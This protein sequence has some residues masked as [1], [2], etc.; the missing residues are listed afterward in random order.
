MRDVPPDDQRT[1][2]Q[3]RTQLEALLVQYGYAA[4][5][6]PI[7]E[8]RDLY[9]RKLGEELV[10]K[11]YEFAFGGRNLALRP[12][13]TASVL[14]AYVAHLQDQPLPL[15]LSYS[16]P[17]F[18]YERPQRL[19]Y[20]QF[21]Q[22]GVEM[23]G[24][25]PPRADA[26]IIALASAGLD[27][28]GVKS[29][30]V[31]IGHLGLVRE[32]LTQL[33]LAERTQGLLAWGLEQ[34]R[35]HGPEAVRERLREGQSDLPFDPVLFQGLDDEQATTLLLNLLRAMRVDLAFGT[36][37]PEDIARRLLRKLRRDESQP[38]ID[39]ALDLLGRLSQ[40]NGIA[41]ETLPQVA[42]LLDEAGL[43]TTTLDEIGAV[44]ALL[45]AHG[46][47]RDR[48]I[49]DF[50][51]GRGLHYYTG[52]IFEMYD[53][54]NIQLC[55]GGRYDDLV[56]ALGGRQSI[57]A[58]GFAYGVERVVA[59]IEQPVD[60]NATRREVLVAPVTDHDYAYALEAARRLRAR[61]FVVTLDVRGRSVTS[62]LRDAARRGIAYVAI[63]GSEERERRE[64]VWRNLDTREE[65]RVSIDEL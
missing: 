55:G 22:V 44:L 16:G 17:V 60:N 23:V 50:G 7:V 34:I 8:H 15:R 30:R 4:L 45:D 1:L 3:V 56:L 24:G 20:R 13:W 48:V 11:I 33:G 31:V 36:R 37:P 58:V 59:A 2:Y 38:R 12:E 9:L 35:T 18:R 27:A 5:D 39:Q 32:M 26:E 65:R 52:M 61:S 64:V 53:S 54:N 28:V 46:L 47:A 57:P 14:R 63:V 10:G 62:N 42:S 40:I 49:L 21:T 6:L 19:T 29:H 51:L 25:P 41:A 43:T